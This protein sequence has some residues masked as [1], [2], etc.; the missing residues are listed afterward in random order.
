MWS[1]RAGSHLKQRAEVV[2]ASPPWVPTGVFGF[3]FHRA[4]WAVLSEFLAD[5]A[6]TFTGELLFSY[7]MWCLRC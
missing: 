3:H 2:Q 6:A 7:G 1:R 4:F 5:V